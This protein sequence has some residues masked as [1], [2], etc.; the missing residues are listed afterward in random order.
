MIHPKWVQFDIKKKSLQMAKVTKCNT[1]VGWFVQLIYD[2][3]L[4]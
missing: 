2:N 3:D 1:S 4:L